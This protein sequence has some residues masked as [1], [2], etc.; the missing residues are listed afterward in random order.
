M[1]KE[2]KNKEEKEV[3][4]EEKKI[5]E[6]KEV[7]KEKEVNE[8]RAKDEEETH[9]LQPTGFGALKSLGGAAHF[10]VLSIPVPSQHAP[11][12]VAMQQNR[13]GSFF[14]KCRAGFLWPGLNSPILQ[15]NVV[16]KP[17]QRGDAE[18]KM[19]IE[20][21]ELKKKQHEM[22]RK[23]KVKRARGWTGNSWGGVCLGPVVD[24]PDGEKYEDFQAYILELKPVFTVTKKESRKRSM[25]ALV[26]VGNGNGLAGF[27][28]GKG[29]DKNNALRKATRRAM[30]VLYYI[31][32]YNDY[33]IYHDITKRFKR[34]TLLMRRQ[35]RG[36]GLRCHRAIITLCKLIGIK[37]LYVKVHGSTNI[38]NITR[39]FFLGLAHQ[40]TH[41]NLA[42]KKQLN[43][44][45]FRAEQGSLPIVVARPEL[46]AR[47]E[48]EIVEDVPNSTLYWYDIKASQGLKKSVWG[49]VKRPPA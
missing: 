16:L 26:A 21:I 40:E 10:S 31:E 20:E 32:R 38:M 1:K 6:K 17:K 48:P 29:A 2:T 23:I 19:K 7:E 5:K 25:S 24:G 35:C 12:S 33:T 37:D 13:H 22:Q 18:Q 11:V 36:Y 14:N 39:A 41:Q 28:L 34:T 4:T 47:Q 45:E 43:V 46:G 49:K 9:L 8:V 42:D 44:I 27:A 30:N 15:A 3:E